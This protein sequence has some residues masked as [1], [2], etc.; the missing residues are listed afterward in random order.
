M[1]YS[2]EESKYIVLLQDEQK[3]DEND[4]GDTTPPT[5]LKLKLQ[6]RTGTR[7]KEGKEIASE[8]LRHVTLTNMNAVNSTQ[9]SATGHKTETAL[10]QVYDPTC[11]TFVS[12]EDQSNVATKFGRR[13]RCT[14]N[15]QTQTHERNGPVLAIAGRF[16]PYD[17]GMMIMTENNTHNR[18]EAWEMPNIPE[19][20]T[21]LNVW[22]GAI[23]LYVKSK[24]EPQ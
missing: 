10:V 5:N 11:H 9:A 19:A 3:N 8:I 13:L 4:D 20:G 24:F 7:E 23:L 18:L 2:N 16:Y 12:L 21:G 22:D 14:V 17:N 1:S 15:R 6:V